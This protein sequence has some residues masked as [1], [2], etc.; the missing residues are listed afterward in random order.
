VLKAPPSLADAVRA[1]MAQRLARCGYERYEVNAS[2][3]AA[4]S[5]LL[6]W[7]S[8]NSSHEGPAEDLDSPRAVSIPP[9]PSDPTADHS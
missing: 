9:A 7:T 2:A 4:T 5:R 1:R 3:P 6:Q 8:S